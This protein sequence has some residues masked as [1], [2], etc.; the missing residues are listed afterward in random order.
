M[1][2]VHQQTSLR[3]PSV[4]AQ[5]L[6]AGTI[7]GGKG[8]VPLHTSPNTHLM[9]IFQGDDCL[10]GYLPLQRN[11]PPTHQIV[12][13]RYSQESHMQ[14]IF[15]SHIQSLPRSPWAHTLQWEPHAV[16]Y[17]CI[18]QSL[19]AHSLQV[20]FTEEL[21]IRVSNVTREIILVWLGSSSC[22]VFIC[23]AGVFQASL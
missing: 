2:H 8:D 12:P 6:L 21:V 23:Q 1:G 14:C 15:Q 10:L 11:I 16:D 9:D 3:L 18:D 13:S 19:R 22:A 17:D 7:V 20:M 4:S 5:L